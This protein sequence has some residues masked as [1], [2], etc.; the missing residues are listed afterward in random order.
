MDKA[1]F[2]G[3]SFWCI[4][5]TFRS[6]EGVTN[7]VSGYS[8]GSE[9]NTNYDDV[10]NQRTG[11]RETI[12]VDFDPAAVSFETLLQI[13]LDGVDP[14]MLAASLSIGDFP[15]RWRCII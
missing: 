11:H 15:T 12:C 8:G 3:G 4:T 6:L 5:P 13:Y 10:K 9:K 1:Y 14:L 2:A 7:V